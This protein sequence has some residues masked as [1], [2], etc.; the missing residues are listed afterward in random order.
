MKGKVQAAQRLLQGVA[1]ER[2]ELRPIGLDLGQRVLL[3]KVADRLARL[4]P[5]VDSRFQR[6][7]GQLAVQPRPRLEPLGLSVTLRRC[8]LVFD[9]AE[10]GTTSANRPL[11]PLLTGRR[12][13]CGAARR[14]GR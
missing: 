7:V 10:D 11:D 14:A 9:P 5:G 4:A 13:L 6:R 2:N 3:I 12:C 8:M 1:A